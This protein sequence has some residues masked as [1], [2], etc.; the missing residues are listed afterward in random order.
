VRVK[1]TIDISIALFALTILAAPLALIA[2]AIWLEDRRWPFYPGLRVGR[3]HTLF[4][5]L[6]FRTMHPQA[7]KTGVNSTASGDPRVT[8]AGRILRRFKLDELPQFVNVLVGQMSLVGPRPQVPTD[9]SLYTEEERKL[10]RVRPGLTDMASIV[11]ADE[12][13]ILAGSAH[14]DLLYNQIIRPWKS[15]LALLYIDRI[16]PGLDLRI[17]AL[18]MLAA[19]SRRRALCGV[20][21]LLGS[22]KAGPLLRRAALREAPLLAYPPPGATGIVADYPRAK[23]TR[24]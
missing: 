16:S 19:V 12:A 22:W 21:H 15:R 18:T 5:M 1:R 11:F 17:L 2:V 24:A 4:R 7:W 8:R 23:A 14:P 9:A 6:K 20:A 3:N 13:E 10:L